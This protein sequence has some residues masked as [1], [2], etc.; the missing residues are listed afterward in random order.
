MSEMEALQQLCE[1]VLP[2]VGP[3][4]RTTTSSEQCDLQYDAAV[5]V[6]GFYWGFSDLL[7]LYVTAVEWLVADHHHAHAEYWVRCH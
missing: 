3:E 5:A 4:Y 6:T 7:K 2:H 1:M